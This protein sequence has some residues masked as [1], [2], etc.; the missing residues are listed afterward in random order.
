MAKPPKPI[1]IG[2]TPH[3]PHGPI[4]ITASVTLAAVLTNFVILESYENANPPS[5]NQF[6]KDGPLIKGNFYPV[7]DILGL[8]IEIDESKLGDLSS[9]T[10]RLIA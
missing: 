3:N 9:D 10:E 5:R 7:S 4:A 1:S 2:V 6:V 8:G